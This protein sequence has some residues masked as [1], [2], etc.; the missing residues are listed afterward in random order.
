MVAMVC[1]PRGWCAGSVENGEEDKDLLDDWV[2]FQGPVGQRAM[3]GQGGS[4]TT[5]TGEEKGR[6]EHRPTRQ[7]VQHQTHK[8]QRVDHNDKYQNP[9]VAAFQ[10][11]TR[12]VSTGASRQTPN[13]SSLPPS[14]VLRH[15]A[16]FY[17]P[18][19]KTP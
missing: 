18:T 9:D 10:L 14:L 1:D 15:T 8:R 17:Q 6:Q 3:V 12:A 19:K 7:G 16:L 5:E 4:E 2:E 13:P 11:C